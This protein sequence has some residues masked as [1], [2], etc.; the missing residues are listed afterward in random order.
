MPTHNHV[1]H[2][3][4]S[5]LAFLLGRESLHFDFAAK[6]IKV[7]LEKLL[8]LLHALAAA[9]SRPNLAQ[10]FEVCHGP[11]GIE[12]DIVPIGG[13]LLALLLPVSLSPLLPF[14]PSFLCRLTPDP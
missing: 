12:N 14:S 3:H 5:G 13:E 4:R 1:G 11:S 8:L 9:N 2:I 6:A 10:V 7:L